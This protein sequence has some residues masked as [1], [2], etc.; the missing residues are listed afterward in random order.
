MTEKKSTVVQA[1]SLSATRLSLVTQTQLTWGLPGGL[2]GTS[3]QHQMTPAQ[4]FQRKR[5]NM[6]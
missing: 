1:C 6:E 4:P 5:F 3:K 2:Q